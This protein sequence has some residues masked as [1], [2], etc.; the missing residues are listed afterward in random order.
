MVLIKKLQALAK[1]AIRLANGRVYLQVHI[2][3]NHLGLGGDS[4]NEKQ[5]KKALHRVVKLNK[6]GGPKGPP[7]K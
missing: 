4:E 1:K 3:I 5:K 2:L 6:K 7:L